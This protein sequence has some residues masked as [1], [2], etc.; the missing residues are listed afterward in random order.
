[1][2]SPNLTQP[3]VPPPSTVPPSPPQTASGS[4]VRRYHT[5]SAHGRS[6]RG[7]S[8]TTISE[9]SGDVPAGVEDEYLNPEEEWI[10]PSAGA[11]GDKNASLH[12]Q[13]SLPTKYHTNKSVF[14]TLISHIRSQ[15]RN[16]TYLHHRLSVQV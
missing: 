6:A 15:H 4:G 12:R 10:A 1:M 2:S 9:E 3:A 7:P 11:I 13:A 16:I 14:F 8:R 5:I